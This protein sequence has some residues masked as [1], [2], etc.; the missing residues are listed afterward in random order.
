MSRLNRALAKLPKSVRQDVRRRLVERAVPDLS[1]PGGGQTLA[2][3]MGDAD[4]VRIRLTDAMA[5]AFGE[6]AGMTG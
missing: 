3:V 2:D 4:A 6:P 1:V 5:E